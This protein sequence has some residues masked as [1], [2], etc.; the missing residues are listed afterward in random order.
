[1]P[2][3]LQSSID[4]TFMDSAHFDVTLSFP[5]GFELLDSLAI[6]NVEGLV[7][8]TYVDGALK[9]PE[10]SLDAYATVQQEKLLRDLYSRTVHPGYIDE[11]YPIRVSW[12]HEDNV[13]QA[14]CYLSTCKVPGGLDF[15]RAELL[16][17]SFTLR[18]I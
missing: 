13:T 6:H 8:F 16:S 4:T 18:V 14:E 15:S 11:T 5:R 12:G 17:V 3:T 9:T 2:L 7:P 10:Y 1:M